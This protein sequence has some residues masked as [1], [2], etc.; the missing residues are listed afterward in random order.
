LKKGAASR[1]GHSGLALVDFLMSGID[2]AVTKDR[3]VRIVLADEA[4]HGLDLGRSE[5]IVIAGDDV[6]ADCIGEAGAGSH[7]AV[8][9][10]WQEAK[11]LPSVTTCQPSALALGMSA[12]GANQ[13]RR[14]GTNDVNDPTRT[15]AY[16]T[17][18]ELIASAAAQ[19]WAGGQHLPNSIH[20]PARPSHAESNNCL[21]LALTLC[22]REAVQS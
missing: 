20:F 13:T 14:D 22:G 15:W 21:C 1:W 18:V 17:A 19:S 6:R 9:L 2:L 16:I 8:I 12:L 10:T 11:G 3:R 5:I 4:L 7:R